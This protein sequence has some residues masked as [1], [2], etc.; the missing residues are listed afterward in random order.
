[1]Y[2]GEEKDSTYEEEEVPGIRRGKQNYICN[3]HLLVVND[4]DL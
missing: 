3:L 2:E 1:M 4:E